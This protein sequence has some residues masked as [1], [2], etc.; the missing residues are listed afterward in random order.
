MLYYRGNCSGR[1]GAGSNKE[2]GALV[3]LIQTIIRPDH[4]WI[5][6]D[7]RVS[8]NNRFQNDD[9]V[10][11]VGILCPDGTA[12]LSYTGLAELSDGTKMSVWVRSVLRGVNRDV[13]STVQAISDFANKELSTYAPMPPLNFV[14]AAFI[15]SQATLYEIT[16]IASGNNP[17][18]HFSI[19]TPLIDK[20]LY[21]AAGSGASYI[22]DEERRH[23]EAIIANG[24]GSAEDCPNALIEL[25][26]KV[27]EKDKERVSASCI[28][29][30]M[31]KTGLPVNVVNGS[32]NISDR[33]VPIVLF[34]IDT[35]E[36]MRLTGSRL[37]GGKNHNL[38][39]EDIDK[40]QDQNAIDAVTPRKVNG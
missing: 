11:Y 38:P 27:A 9:H 1:S 40:I 19:Q 30:G 21:H 10:K 4:I 16:N 24:P 25:N 28:V 35:T 13:K 17:S 14:I 8:I 29:V 5:C 37:P 7:N 6:T 33:D 31:P 2:R 34:G 39:Q 20:P 26:K 32:Q 22:T 3:T 18:R 23:L 36:M 12:L 15:G